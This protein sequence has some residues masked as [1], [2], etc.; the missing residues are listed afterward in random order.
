MGENDGGDSPD[1]AIQPDGRPEHPGHRAEGGREV[2]DAIEGRRRPPRP[3]AA[4]EIGDSRNSKQ[5]QS[6]KIYGQACTEQFS[7]QF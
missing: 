2:V 3:S 5:N 7:R 1:M 6:V 4:R